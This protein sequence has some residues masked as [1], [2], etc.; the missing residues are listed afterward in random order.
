[1][2]NT[3]I[4]NNSNLLHPITKF[5]SFNQLEVQL[6]ELVQQKYVVKVING[7]L[8]TYKYSI[9]CSAKKNWNNAT[10]CARGLILD[11]VNKKVVALPFPKFFNIGREHDES[12]SSL[13][14]F[15]PNGFYEKMDGSCGIIYFYNKKWRVNTLGE[16][17]TD[18]AIWAKN[19]LDKNIDPN[20]LNETNTYICEII[21]PENKIIVDY[22]KAEG[23]CLIGKYSNITGKELTINPIKGF[24]LP[25]TFKFDS[26][27]NAIESTEIFDKNSEGYV[28]KS[29]NGNR[30]KIKS[31]AYRDMQTM[32][33]KHTPL[34]LWKKFTFE[35]YS[36]CLEYKKEIPQ[37]LWK[38][39]D[40][41]LRL[42]TKNYNHIENNAVQSCH[43]LTRNMS[44]KEI[45]LAINSGK[46]KSKYSDFFFSILKDPKNFAQFNTKT[47]K[48]FCELF[49]PKANN[50]I[51]L[52]TK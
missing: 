22:G 9:Q 8:T 42:F 24:S 43:D 49:K 52:T 32:L 47:H 37:E 26:M 19:Y 3:K 48:A 6:E 41:W 29:K 30:V 20:S 38:E 33:S 5:D 10:I 35:G 50:L 44:F 25:K 14:H 11:T 31:K 46:I 13:A 34:D 12:G 45:A 51:D 39:Y 36:S 15:N 18:Q 27:G 16:F 23:L 28:Y 7:D 4:N 21:Y 17:T 1:M 2:F 40:S